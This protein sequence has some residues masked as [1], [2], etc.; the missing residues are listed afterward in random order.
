M[1]KQ[2]DSQEIKRV[3]D[4]IAPGWYNRF[5]WTRFKDD[6]AMLAQ[7]WGSGRLINLGCGHGADFLP[8]K[9]TFDLSGVDISP[10]MLEQAE[11][12]A[13]KFGY[14][15]RLYC[16]DVRNLPF[17]NEI[18]DW[19]LAVATFHHLN[20]PVEINR[21][22]VELYRVL[23]PGGEAFVTFWNRCQPR[24]WFKPR[25]L[26]VPWKTGDE[27]FYRYYYLV[28]FRQAE[29]LA[30]GAGFTIIASSPEKSYRWPV[31]LFSKNVCL[32]LRKPSAGPDQ[33]RQT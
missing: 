6:L 15:P 33:L 24:F 11:R 17:E 26:L 19:A 27:T 25:E 31:K 20:G 2:A 29:R 23:K 28:S 9:H 32:L 12:Y 16:G 18:F 22:M 13:V 5:H 14:Q 21:G 3:F 4:A 8:F 7:R 10:K 30:A 1:T